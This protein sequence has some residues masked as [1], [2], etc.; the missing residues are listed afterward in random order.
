[1]DLSPE[2]KT[3]AENLNQNIKFSPESLNSSIQDLEDSR[4][5]SDHQVPGTESD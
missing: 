2:I 5:Q 1:M 4:I 3:P